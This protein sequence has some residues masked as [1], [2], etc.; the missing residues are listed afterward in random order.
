MPKKV[1]AGRFALFLACVAALAAAACGVTPPNPHVA[2]DQVDLPVID[3][4]LILRCRQVSADE[5]LCED[6]IRLRR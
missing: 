6:A 4:K 3:V 2:A 1:N 5:F